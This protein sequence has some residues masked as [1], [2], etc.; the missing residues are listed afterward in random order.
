ML[1]V[2]LVLAAC[3]PPEPPA[4]PP[5]AQAP[6]TPRKK[7]PKADRTGLVK[8]R[9]KPCLGPPQGVDEEAGMV[10][11]EGLDPTDA[12]RALNRFAPNVLVCLGESSP[13][14]TLHLRLRVA[15]SGVVD[16]VEVVD[17]GDWPEPVAA[18]VAERVGYAELPA[19]GL[20]DGDVV[21]WPLRYTAP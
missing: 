16:A 11:S 17:R 9:P 18:C 2:W 8:P 6:P 7:Q 1:P 14:G 10:A 3:A 20:P 19:H 12:G 4:P 21:D 5:P 13:T 15:C